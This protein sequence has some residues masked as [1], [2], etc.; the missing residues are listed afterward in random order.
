[1]NE[2]A[3]A[4]AEAETA[5]QT[6]KEK[7]RT[8]F[9]EVVGGSASEHEE[10]RR[11]FQTRLKECEENLRRELQIDAKSSAEWEAKK[12]AAAIVEESEENAKAKAAWQNF[13]EVANSCLESLDTPQ[14]GDI[15]I[16]GDGHGMLVTEVHVG[17]RKVEIQN[18]SLV[19]FKA[20]KKGLRDKRDRWGNSVDCR[21]NL[22]TGE[23]LW[24]YKNEPLEFMSA[25]KY[26][27]RNAK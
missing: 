18:V 22:M 6:L 12:Q 10:A 14:V 9:T 7:E 27:E 5:E 2:L 4:L 13:R 20:T 21:V 3:A 17:S 1:M 19:G 25:E 15:V 24:D 11:I 16:R 23:V 26:A 8:V